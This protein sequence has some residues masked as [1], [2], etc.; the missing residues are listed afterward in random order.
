MEREKVCY[1]LAGSQ[2]FL[3]VK[4]SHTRRRRRRRRSGRRKRRRGRKGRRRKEDHQIGLVPA[5]T[6]NKEMM[7]C[8]D[9]SFKTF[10]IV[11]I[12]H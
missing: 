12:A 9:L 2:E 7:D 3:N 5:K 10:Q 6:I 1:W 4:Y 8:P 11:F